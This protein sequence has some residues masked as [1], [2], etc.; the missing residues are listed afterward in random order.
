[1]IGVNDC[2][3]IV[4]L[5]YSAAYPRVGH[6]ILFSML[7]DLEVQDDSSCTSKRVSASFVAVPLQLPSS[8]YKKN[9]TSEMSILSMMIDLGVRIGHPIYIY[10]TLSVGVPKGW[11]IFLFRPLSRFCLKIFLKGWKFS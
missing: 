7:S 4:T 2:L 10:N 6:T 8:I 3:E 1:M 11:K 5:L 9:K